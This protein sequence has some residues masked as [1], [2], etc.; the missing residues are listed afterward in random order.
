[1]TSAIMGRLGAGGGCGGA[2]TVP[3]IVEGTTT[4]PKFSPDVGGLA[5]GM[6][7][8]Q[9]SC[10]GGKQTSGSG[11]QPASSNPLGALSGLLGKKK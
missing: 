3:F 8:S 9:L 7:K 6:L 10:L 4:E 11:Q 1:M 5:A 2:T